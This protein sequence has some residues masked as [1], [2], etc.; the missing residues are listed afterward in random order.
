VRRLACIAA[1]LLVLASTGCGLTL[2]GLG[3]GAA[4]IFGADDSTT[5]VNAPSTVLA[6]PEARSVPRAVSLRL[7]VV[8]AE[9][10]EVA[11]LVEY[12]RVDGDTGALATTFT[13]ALVV[14][15][16]PAASA[17]PG[18]AAGSLHASE[19]GVVTDLASS[20]SGVEHVVVWDASTA[21]LPGGAFEAEVRYT[22]VDPTSLAALSDAVTFRMTIG[23]DP[24]AVSLAVEGGGAV[25][26]NATLGFRLSDSTLDRCRIEVEFALADAPTAFSAAAIVVGAVDELASSAT[27]TGAPIQS[28]AW[29]TDAPPPGGVGRTNQPLVI[30]RVTPVD[31]HE[32]V[33]P[34]RSRGASVTTTVRIANNLPPAVRPDAVNPFREAGSPVPI[35]YTLFDEDLDL[36]DLAVEV[37]VGAD[38]YRP[39][40]ERPIGRGARELSEGNAALA[41]GPFPDGRPH[42][43]IWDMLADVPEAGQPVRLRFTPRDAFGTGVPVEIGPLPIAPSKPL[44][45]EPGRE[46]GTA[47]LTLGVIDDD[48]GTPALL[49][50]VGDRLAM[51]SIALPGDVG[52]GLGFQERLEVRAFQSGTPLGGGD[53]TRILTLEDLDFGGTFQAVLFMNRSQPAARFEVLSAQF[54]NPA[55]PVL[56]TIVELAPPPDVFSI[57]DAVTGDFDDDESDDIAVLFRVEDAGANTHGCRLWV[58]PRGADEFRSP[59]E[60]TA[61]ADFLGRWAAFDAPPGA[62][63]LASDLDGDGDQ[64]LVA[65]FSPAIGPERGRAT[66]VAARNDRAPLASFAD[67]R[68]LEDPALV[69]GSTS[70]S[71]L[72]DV[73]A[74]GTADLDGDGAREVL[75]SAQSGTIFATRRTR[76]YGPSAAGGLERRDVEAADRGEGRYL[77]TIDVEGDGTDEVVLAAEQLDLEGAGADLF[78]LVPVTGGAGLVTEVRLYDVGEPETAIADVFAAIAL[79]LDQDAAID[80]AI[81]SEDEAGG[82]VLVLLAN[83]GLGSP[84]GARRLTTPVGMERLFA[85]DLEGD[86][87]LDLV[88]PHPAASNVFRNPRPLGV[89]PLPVPLFDGSSGFEGFVQHRLA[90]LDGDGRRDIVAYTD[91][92]SSIVTLRATSDGPPEEPRFLP[93]QPVGLSFSFTTLRRDPFHGRESV[94]LY[95]DAPGFLVHLVEA[96]VG[97]GGAPAAPVLVSATGLSASLAVIAADLDADGRDDLILLDGDFT[98]GNA[99][100]AALRRADG[101]FAPAVTIVPGV[102]VATLDVA[103]VDGDGATDAA[104]LLGDEQ[105][106]EV[107]RGVPGSATM[108]GAAPLTRTAT[109]DLGFTVR[110]VGLVDATGDGRLDVCVYYFDGYVGV[111]PQRED[112][113]FD[114]ADLIDGVEAS[115]GFFS[116]T[117]NRARLA[118]VDVDGDGRGEVV[119]VSEEYDP[120][121]DAVDLAVVTATVRPDGTLSVGRLPALSSF[122][123][124]DLDRI[125]PPVL[126]DPDGD[127][128]DNLLV[129]ITT[130][131]GGLGP[132]GSA[133]VDIRPGPA[134]SLS[135]RLAKE[136]LPKI[137]DA[138]DAT[139]DGSADIVSVTVGDDLVLGA[140]IERRGA[141]ARFLSAL[142]GGSVSAT[143]SP[144]TG[145][146]VE[147]P[148]GARRADRTL[149]LIVGRRLDLPR[150]AGAVVVAGVA[151]RTLA[152]A[153]PPV[154]ILPETETLTAD[155]TID[156]PLDLR[157]P[158]LAPLAAEADATL[159]ARIT[160]HRFEREALRGRGRVVTLPGPVAV[161]TDPAS[162]ARVVR[163]Q[164]SRFGVYQAAI[165]R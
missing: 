4:A 156:L 13:A 137:I 55:F 103:D 140:A 163:F 65:C 77:A 120:C 52:Y 92:T 35:E 113:S 84:T 118:G 34:A 154:A 41:S 121:R 104:F 37:R 64:D 97:P 119:V 112:G 164:A 107:L 74:L 29:R 122:F 114:M 28:V 60:V 87:D 27:L 95:D 1:L 148:A 123:G 110:T 94:A 138:G 85:T 152:P 78:R 111:V 117:F 25:R 31:E 128:R 49:G 43:F 141:D 23:N 82:R 72:G 38:P 69:R 132:A 47:D 145:A 80:L 26:G 136:L 130:L 24:P 158:A 5:V 86:G 75:V 59:V 30:V 71:D 106:V 98:T 3:I 51:Q 134:G 33:D 142:T 63:L 66:L 91:S 9:G 76:V 44:D 125:G 16:T 105:T 2:T 32:G 15:T 58:Y 48:L 100:K 109:L 7:R 14:S 88:A 116:V 139:G 155:A 160:I 153:S 89:R 42:A 135:V 115:C 12:A 11:I 18:T 93:E 19:R 83:D 73:V 161:V 54:L 17:P 127:G 45:L 39:A 46:P 157:A 129:P 53:A 21:D 68:S 61:R 36:V 149:A 8:D 162:G 56:E 147:V 133:L 10:D 96:G 90:D 62:A 79:D 81:L 20:S 143:A 57:V 126:L 67:V 159:A 144:I 70:P 102:F 22:I 146:R 151:D 124:P 6:V 165:A 40:T 101:G 99:I 108:T 150:A 131:T 50:V